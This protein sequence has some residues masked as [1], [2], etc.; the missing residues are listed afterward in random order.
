M[1]FRDKIEQINDL[2]TKMITLE[3]ETQKNEFE[4][5]HMGGLDVRTD[6]GF[7]FLDDGEQARLKLCVESILN[8]RISAQTTEW[9]KLL[10]QAEDIFNVE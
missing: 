2:R 6:N 3:G 8:D 7:M 10:Q 5:D 1:I 4:R 9:Q